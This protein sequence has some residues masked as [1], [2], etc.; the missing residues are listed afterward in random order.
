MLQS[1]NLHRHPLGGS[2]TSQQESHISSVW[3]MVTCPMKTSQTHLSPNKRTL[4][5][6]QCDGAKLPH[7]TPSTQQTL[8][9]PLAGAGRATA[10]LTRA[11]GQFAVIYPVMHFVW[12]LVHLLA[13]RHPPSRCNTCP[14]WDSNWALDGARKAS[15]LVKTEEANIEEHSIGHSSNPL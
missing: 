5:G 4:T 12:E 3:T 1:C 14:L 7:P 10:S 13:V 15:K 6:S 11:R 9:P 2:R 8:F